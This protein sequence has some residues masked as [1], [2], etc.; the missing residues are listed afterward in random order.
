MVFYAWGSRKEFGLKAR[1]LVEA[2]EVGDRD[3]SISKRSKL[4]NDAGP[5]DIKCLETR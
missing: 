5:K 4:A 2:A 3:S 1:R